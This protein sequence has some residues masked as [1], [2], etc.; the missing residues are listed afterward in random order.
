MAD[1][2][3]KIASDEKCTG[4][5]ACV[6]KCPV[7]ALFMKENEEG[8]LVP[9]VD[10]EKCIHCGICSK[11]CPVD[12]ASAGNIHTAG[13]PECYA[14]MAEDDI[15]D[16]SSSGGLFTLLAKFIIERGGSVCGA[17]F[18]PDW[19]V[20][21]IIIDNVDDLDKLR[22]SKYVQSNINTCYQKIKLLLEDDR[23]ILFSG[24]PC[25]VAGLYAYLGKDYKKLLTMDILCHGAPSPGVW[26]KYLNENFKS[27]K[28]ISVNFRDKKNIGWSC[29]KVTVKTDKKEY[30]SD[31]YTKAFHKSIIN[32]K[33]CS[34]CNFSAYPR[35]ADI[36]GG[37]FWGISDYSESMNDKKGTSLVL[38]NSSKG[39]EVFSNLNGIKNL[40]RIYLSKDYNNGCLVHNVKESYARTKF[41]EL[42][43]TM[44]YKN[45]LYKSQ[46]F[47]IGVMGFWYGMNYGSQLTY[48][49]L[50]RTLQDLGKS[51]LMIEKPL[52]KDD[53]ELSN[54]CLSRQFANSHYTIS[55]YRPLSRLGE[56]NNCCEA[57]I[58]GSDQL[59][60]KNC[61]KSFKDTL[62]FN[63][64][65][66]DKRKLAYAV[67][68]GHQKF[69]PDFCERLKIH[70][71]L[72]RF[73]AIS[74]REKSGVDI[75]KNTLN[76]SGV[77]VLD[78]IFLCDMR[79]YESL[80]NETH[81]P[82]ENNYILSYILDPCQEKRDLLTDIS[83]KTGKKLVN[84]LDA[85]VFTYERNKKNLNLDNIKDT[86]PVQKFLTYF[87]NA[88]YIV[89]DSF[90][91]TCVAILFKKQFIAVA[92]KKRGVT[93]FESLL[94]VFDLTDRLVYNPHDAINNDKLFEQID[95]DKVYSILNKERNRSLNW[96]NSALN[97]PIKKVKWNFAEYLLISYFKF[98]THIDIYITILKYYRYKLLSL[99]TS[100][101][102]K[103][104]YIRKREIY[105]QHVRDY[106]IASKK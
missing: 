26:I 103:K 87:K 97:S 93:R 91:G 71:Y 80:I 68:F 98:S 1:N 25:Q 36:T 56:L 21:H 106:R 11:V 57:F 46:M 76:V 74:V 51:V 6:N 37:D 49:A 3:L 8:F 47:D 63:F 94:S 20:S 105:H 100:G 16:K 99:I 88:D 85:W 95:Y 53:Y 33:S 42:N 45:A 29:S 5:G 48:F 65:N 9:V 86:M 83:S 35:P 31:D 72:K 102:K 77:Y 64:V 27:E 44:S 61:Y 101:E 89:T 92:N 41:F 19:S 54:T 50:N 73:N 23:Y 104:H 34:D 4:C 60:H 81:L 13:S 18:N 15:R 84:I 43:K 32:R 67:S 69:N 38:L 59:W 28:I 14:I 39:N 22:G 55:K 58:L 75:L 40:E 2:H 90:H 30:V 12:G 62:F 96:L 24:C 52:A 7:N 66:S 79:H 70:C 10:E 17:A 82:E 78:P